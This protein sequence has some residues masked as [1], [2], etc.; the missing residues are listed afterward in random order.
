IPD[1]AM[2]LAASAFTGRISTRHITLDQ[3]TTQDVGHWWKVFGQTLPALA[4]GQFG[5]PT[6]SATCLHLSARLHQKPT[7]CCICESPEVRISPTSLI[8]KEIN[9]LCEVPGQKQLR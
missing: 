1:R 9:L 6:Q 5:Q 3:R 7:A 8:Q 2:P 4:Q